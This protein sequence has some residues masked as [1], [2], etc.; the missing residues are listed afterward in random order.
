MKDL[1]VC[2]P[3]IKSFKTANLLYWLNHLYDNLQVIHFGKKK[4]TLQKH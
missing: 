3:E 2:D 1:V 4:K